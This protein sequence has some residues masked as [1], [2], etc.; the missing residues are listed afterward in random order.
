VVDAD[1]GMVVVVFMVFMAFMVFM[2]VM[3]VG[4]EVVLS[5]L[6]VGQELVDEAF[7]LL[8]RWCR[9]AAE[10]GWD[11]VVGDE[12]ALATVGVGRVEDDLQGVS[13]SSMTVSGLGY[14][15]L[16]NRAPRH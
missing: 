10:V 9:R 11:R 12:G 14:L 13:C 3:T 1:I 2:V 5:F 4:R 15:P 6:L 7:C 8:V 16:P